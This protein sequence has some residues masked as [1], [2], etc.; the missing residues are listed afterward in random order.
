[1]RKLLLLGILALNIFSIQIFAQVGKISGVVKDASTNEALI[2]AN[3]LI[4]GT[5]I[6][7]ATNVDGYYSII[8]VSPGTY[9]LRV[10]MIGYT[11]QM[12]KDV[13]V[14]IDLTTELNANL[15]SS[16]F[17][18]EEVVVVAVQTIVKQDV[19]ASV[20]NLNI[21]EIENLPVSSVSSVIGLQAGVQGLTIR[22]GA[23]DQTAFV[24]NGI[25]L[26]DA[27]DNTPYTGISLTSVGDI[28]IQTGGFNAEYGDIRS[29]LI[30][31]VTKEGKRD[32]Y[33]F[34]F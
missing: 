26:R 22:G 15:K 4:E 11:P 13:R 23:S 7:A 8:N 32:K 10:S 6:G 12:I 27:R 34:A 1:M 14:N 30:N 5:T 24:V 21:K 20:T 16:T 9:N 31:V 19:S 3:V 33:N 25:T 28:Q 17:E 29:G 18:T 2:G